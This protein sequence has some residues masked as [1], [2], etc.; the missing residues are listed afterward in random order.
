M[1]VKKKK[2]SS[3]IFLDFNER[4]IGY[5]TSIKIICPPGVLFRSSPSMGGFRAA[6]FLVALRVCDLFLFWFPD[7][8]MYSGIIVGGKGEN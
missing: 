2:K 5:T 7:V 6:D 4:Y 1:Y 3:F 8:Y